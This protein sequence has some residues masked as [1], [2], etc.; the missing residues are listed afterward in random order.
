VTRDTYVNALLRLYLNAPGA[1][2]RPSRRDRRVAVELFRQGVSLDHLAH[3]IRVATLRRLHGS[4]PPINSLAYYRVVLE[5]LSG[6]ELHADYVAYILDTYQ[7]L[8]FASKPRAD[9]QN[10][11]LSG[12]R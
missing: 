3:G 4:H 6:D 8:C 9:R 7:R 5:R 11:A 10:P 12:S 1:P 2:R